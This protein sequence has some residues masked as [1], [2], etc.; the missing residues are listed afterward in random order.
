MSKQTHMRWQQKG[1]VDGSTPGWSLANDDGF[2]NLRGP[3]TA[4][5]GAEFRF[6]RYD[7]SSKTPVPCYWACDFYDARGERLLSDVYSSIFP[8]DQMVRN[9]AMIYGR[10][11]SPDIQPFF[12]SVQP[13]EVADLD[14]RAVSSDEVAAWC[15][16]LY[17]ALPPLKYEPPPSRLAHLPRTVQALRA[18][19][20]W[21]MLL[22]G[23]SYYNDIYNSSFQALLKRRYPQCDLR[24]I[25]SG[26]AATGCE[27]YEHHLQR[28]VADLRPDFLLLGGV[29]KGNDIGPI[30][31][32]IEWVREHVG[33]EILLVPP[34]FGPDEREHRDEDRE[35]PLAGQVLD[36]GPFVEV[37]QDLAEQQEIAFLDLQTLWCHYLG[38]SEMPWSWF[39]R[40][41]GHA[42]DRGKQII[43][44][45]IDRFFEGDPS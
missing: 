10:P 6:L 11:G 8:S 36:P 37:Q 9:S 35:T 12:R 22:L 33:C 16:A 23:H 34:P 13:V 20:P 4:F 31:R 42:N 2:H 15:D 40:D 43:A 25:H 30:Q 21:R 27:H 18:G 26:R 5:E 41:K 29:S 38:Q 39:L 28:Y 17:A 32:T 44:R 45:A 24:V 7:F 3:R 14:I 1:I 19:T